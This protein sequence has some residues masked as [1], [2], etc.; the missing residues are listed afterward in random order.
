MKHSIKIIF[1]KEQVNKYHQNE[2]LSI[3]EEKI[4]LKEFSFNSKK[5][6]EAFCL[7]LEEAVGWMEWVGV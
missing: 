4:N 3:E 2:P 6:L 7:G 5:E 1:G